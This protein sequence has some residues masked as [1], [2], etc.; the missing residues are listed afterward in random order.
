MKTKHIG[1][2]C[3]SS[4]VVLL[5]L[6]LFNGCLGGESDD[7]NISYDTSTVL[8]DDMDTP[9]IFPV[10]GKMT[11]MLTGV[12]TIQTMDKDYT[13]E[14][15]SEINCDEVMESVLIE[16]AR[17]RIAAGLSPNLANRTLF[18]SFSGENEEFILRGAADILMARGDI[19]YTFLETII[20]PYAPP[21]NAIDG[22][23]TFKGLDAATERLIKY[24][25]AHWLCMPF[26]WVDIKGY[27]GTYNDCVPVF[28][29]TPVTG[30]L[31]VVTT[32]TVAGMKFIWNSS[33]VT[34]VWK[35]GDGTEAGRFYKLNEAF[36]LGFLNQDDIKNIY[37]LHQSGRY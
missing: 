4:V 23:G 12:A 14:D 35:P 8:V 29:E 20:I 2:I 22:P 18:L 21:T 19:A 37:E 30:L 16:V 28:L 15:F 24:D 5:S 6:L 32:I 27:F 9:V 34:L 1:T 31:G 13:P 26:D 36:D 3:V 11:V 7:L 25:Y 33:N 17:N 10:K